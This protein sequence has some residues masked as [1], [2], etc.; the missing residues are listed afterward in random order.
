MAR[1]LIIDDE[2][3][4]LTLLRR[5]LTGAGHEILTAADGGSGLKILREQELHLVLS[6]LSMPGDPAGIDLLKALLN[7][8]PGCPIA[9]VSGYSSG[10]SIDDCRRIGIKDFL[11]KPFE[12]AYVRTFVTDILSRSVPAA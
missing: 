6:D 5:V 12:I 1:I 2:L 9:V 10:D 4:I 11:P 3:P 7:A 8:R